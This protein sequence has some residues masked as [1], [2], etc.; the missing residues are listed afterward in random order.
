MAV[1]HSFH[2]FVECL[3]PHVALISN[4]TVDVISN[5]SRGYGG[6]VYVDDETNPE[7]CAAVNIQNAS[8]TSECFSTAVF[9]NLWNN[10]A[11]I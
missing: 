8:S 7:L 4:D 1:Q 5:T 11:G 2:Q 10:S 3:D 9:M 6:A